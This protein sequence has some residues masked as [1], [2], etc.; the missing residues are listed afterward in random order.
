[1]K[2]PLNIGTRVKY[3]LRPR[4]RLTYGVIKNIET[5]DHG[6]VYAISDGGFTRMVRA[7]RIREV[8]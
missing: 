2:H 5:D 8:V 7:E 1:M 4:A 3:N 6:V